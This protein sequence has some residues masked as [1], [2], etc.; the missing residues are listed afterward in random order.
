MRK[1]DNKLE[2]NS[3]IYSKWWDKKNNCY[4]YGNKTFKLW[5]NR[6]EIKDWKKNVWKGV[7]T[8]GQLNIF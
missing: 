4:Y 8:N 2:Y 7:Q 5:L 3:T 6:E 1:S